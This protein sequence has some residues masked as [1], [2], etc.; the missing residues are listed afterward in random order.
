MHCYVVLIFT[1]LETVGVGGITVGGGAWDI[2]EHL[3]YFGLGVTCW[4]YNCLTYSN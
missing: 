3:P 2:A 1:G 4:S